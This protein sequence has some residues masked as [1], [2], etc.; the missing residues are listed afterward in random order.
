MLN[1]HQPGGSVGGGALADGSNV[2]NPATWQ[3]N[4]GVPSVLDSRRRALIGGQPGVALD[5]AAAGTRITSALTGQ[6]IGTGDF[7]VW[8]RFRVP[9]LTT[10]QEVAL[11]SVGTLT[12]GLG[13]NSFY[14]QLYGTTA[15]LN[16]RLSGGTSSYEFYGGSIGSLVQN[17]A[18]QVIDLVATRAGSVLKI[19][20]NGNE[21]TLT[22][23]IAVGGTAPA[24]WAATVTSSN[25]VLGQ[26]A[27][28]C[29][30]DRIYRAA[31]FNRALSL[32]DVTEL[33]VN[34]VADAD[35][36]GT[37]TALTMA[38]SGFETDAPGVSPPSSWSTP[39]NH[40]ATVVADSSVEGTKAVEIVASGVGDQSSNNLQRTKPAHVVG[41]R[42]RMSLSARSISGN[43]AL[44]A[45]PGGGDSGTISM[46]LTGAYAVGATEYVSSNASGT[47]RVNLGAA[48]T[49]RVD[50]VKFE[51]LGALVDLN[52]GEG[53][54]L[55]FTDRSTNILH[56]IGVGGIAHVVPGREGCVRVRTTASGNVQLGGAGIIPANGRIRCIT[57]DAV[58]GTPTVTMG[59]AS[60]GAQHVASVAL[61]AGLNDLTAVSRFNTTG[62]LWVN[63]SV[64]ATVDWTVIYDLVD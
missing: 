13:I 41:K 43:T 15:G 11:F 18:G 49:F 26:G 1:L 20:L 17:Y 64:T 52:L 58:S 55:C 9:A 34:G 12:T 7:S 5:G 47:V 28:A 62:N 56:G 14:A 31:L 60:G 21:Q 46:T 38:N 40:V 35:Q 48:G 32:S 59:N 30:P 39:G 61:T 22:G 16:F 57:A 8:L 25:F 37:Q 33:I 51:R 4:L 27:T 42:F 6:N 2:T 29:F 19:Y 44:T 36:W 54:G 10:A 45:V 63:V 50:N 24:N 23:L 53:A 3:A